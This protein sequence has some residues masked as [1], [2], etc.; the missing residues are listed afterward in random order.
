MACDQKTVRLTTGTEYL[1]AFPTHQVA[2]PH[3]STWGYQGYCET[4]LTGSNHRIYPAAFRALEELREVRE[5]GPAFEQ[6]LRELLL[7]QSSD[8]A[9]ILN[10]GTAVPY[11]ARRFETHLGN[12]RLLLD[13]LKSGGGDPE[14]L[15]AMRER[16]N[17]FSG[18][19]LAGLYRVGLAL[20]G[21]PAS[22]RL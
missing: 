8:W 22:R 16:N 9:Y 21:A 15:A 20:L 13:G 4:W 17:L 3:L 7:V 6:A 5:H 2:K 12:L 11:A 14:Q 18:L 1:E 19:D 10:A